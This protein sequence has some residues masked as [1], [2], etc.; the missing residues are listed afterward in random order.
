V[1]G[2]VKPPIEKEISKK[3]K[4]TKMNIAQQLYAVGTDPNSNKS[5]TQQHLDRII[6]DLPKKTVDGQ[7]SVTLTN[8]QAWDQA[9]SIM[10][11]DKA[12]A[13]IM[14]QMDY[15]GFTTAKVDG[16]VVP[17]AFDNIGVF[18]TGFTVQVTHPAGIQGFR[19]YFWR[20]HILSPGFAYNVGQAANAEQFSAPIWAV[21]VDNLIQTPIP[22]S[23]YVTKAQSG[24]TL[25]SFAVVINKAVA[26]TENSD[27]VI[28]VK[29]GMS[30]VFTFQTYVVGE[31][32]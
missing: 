11:N 18:A 21:T 15:S 10:R 16:T 30:A 25:T 7:I 28:V 29:A 3:A 32:R 8:N 31:T 14:G 2:F 20:N 27:L 23:S 6:R 12:N 17:C 26:L 1:F 13:N 22:L 5:Q 24:N 9:F 19:K 4:S